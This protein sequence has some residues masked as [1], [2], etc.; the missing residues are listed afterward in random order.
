M[1][2]RE[3]FM[4]LVLL[5]FPAFVEG[6]VMKSRWLLALDSSQAGLWASRSLFY[7]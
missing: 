5:T 3:P 2:T 7:N 6:E 1:F 4:V